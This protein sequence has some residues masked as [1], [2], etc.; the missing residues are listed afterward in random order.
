VSVAKNCKLLLKGLFTAEL[1][2]LIWPV[3]QGLRWEFAVFMKMALSVFETLSKRTTVRNAYSARLE[4]HVI[5]FF[6]FLIL[7]YHFNCSLRCVF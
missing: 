2:T 7:K 5:S 6:I 4:A 3:L 1:R